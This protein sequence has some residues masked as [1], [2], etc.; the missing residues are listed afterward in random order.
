MLTEI[1]LKSK[2]KRE[3]EDWIAQF[4]DAIDK[5]P[6]SD[7]HSVSFSNVISYYQIYIICLFWYRFQMRLG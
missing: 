4:K 1:S 3:I 7:K 2:W 5:I 6:E